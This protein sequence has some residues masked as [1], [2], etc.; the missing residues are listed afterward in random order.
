LNP[1]LRLVLCAVLAWQA[2]AAAIALLRGTWNG[3][4][5]G[6]AHRLFATTAERIDLT[7]GPDSPVH[8]ALRALPAGAW[9]L[10]AIDPQ[11]A[12]SPEN[13]SRVRL[14]KQLQHLLYPSPILVNP[15]PDAIAFAETKAVPGQPVWLLV[16]A[17]DAEPA[18][19]A[20]WTQTRREE[21]FQLW[22]FQKG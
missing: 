8:A 1:I 22:R 10:A 6:H 3:M 18:G 21:R 19:R 5:H 11:K 13:L 12:T 4:Q 20:G 15:M 7:L 9:V 14:L 16:L 2:V 17:G